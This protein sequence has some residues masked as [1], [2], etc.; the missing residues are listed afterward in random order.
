MQAVTSKIKRRLNWYKAR[1]QINN[2]VV[3]GV[4]ELLGNKVRMDGLTYS[5]A[6]PQITRGHKSTLAFGLH[7]MEERELVRRWVPSDIPVLELGGGLGVVSCLTNHK[8]A[9]RAKHIVVEANPLMATALDR[10]RDLNNCAFRVVNKAIAYDC[11]HVDLNIFDEFV[12]S[13]VKNIEIY[14]TTLGSALQGGKVSIQT[15]TVNKLLDEFDFP[16]AGIV[17]DIEGAEL[18]VVE[19]EFGALGPRIRFFLA[20]MHP[21]ILGQVT[22][23][24][25]L[26]RLSDLGFTMKQQIGDSVYLSR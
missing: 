3:G 6:T 13:S 8:L 26:R 9:N 1:F 7:E 22:V 12:G 10:N 2:P 11:D 23:D 18:D 4:V 17:C 14:K 25:L 15:T 19:R 20:E 21:A 5:V 16:E 24:R